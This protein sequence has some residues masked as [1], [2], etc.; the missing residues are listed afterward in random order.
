[1]KS[2]FV[3]VGTTSFDELITCVSSRPTLQ[4]SRSGIPVGQIPGCRL[5]FFSLCCCKSSGEEAEPAPRCLAFGFLFVGAGSCLEIL[6][7]GKPLVVVVNE[8]LMDNHQLELAKQLHE[9]GYLF[10][11]TC[12]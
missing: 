9:E 6:G 8:K 11:C 3:T 5:L 4:V 12:R 2:V 7:E 1:M 10:Y